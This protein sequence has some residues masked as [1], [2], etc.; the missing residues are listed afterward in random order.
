MTKKCYLE[1]MPSSLMSW[2]RKRKID[3]LRTKSR[4]GRISVVH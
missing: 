4:E 1:I 2:I 3:S